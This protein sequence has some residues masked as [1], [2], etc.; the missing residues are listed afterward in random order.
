MTK[1]LTDLPAE[2]A[3]HRIEAILG[4]GGQGVACLGRHKATGRLAAI[5]L[6]LAQHAADEVYRYRFA[7]EVEALY[8]VKG[9]PNVVR[10]FTDGE[11]NGIPY[12]V[13][14]YMPSGNLRTF[15][16]NSLLPPRTAVRL[17]LPLARAMAFI[18]AR[19]VLIRDVSLENLLV[20]PGGVVKMADLGLAKLTDRLDSPTMLYHPMGRLEYMPCELAD[21]R[22][23]YVTPACDCFELGV[24]LARVLIGRVPFTNSRRSLDEVLDSEVLPPDDFRGVPMT[25]YAVLKKCLARREAARYASAGML[26]QDLQRWLD[27]KPTSAERWPTR[28]LHGLKSSAL[29]LW[30]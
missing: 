29:G 1:T 18:H 20:G 21:G 8:R 15:L 13:M 22:A 25:L 3:G 9:Q 24:V 23:R 7:A 10:I 26:A 14:E 28:W 19:G 2:V 5:K 12:Y 27:G 17:V 6:L 16:G 4:E 11:E 30:L